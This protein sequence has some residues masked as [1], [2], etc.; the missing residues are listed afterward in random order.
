[1][2]TLPSC[3]F[4]TCHFSGNFWQNSKMLHEFYVKHYCH[5]VVTNNKECIY[6]E[7]TCSRRHTRTHIDRLFVRPVEVRLSQVTPLFC[8]VSLLAV[9]TSYPNIFMVCPLHSATKPVFT[10]LS[11]NAD[12][13]SSAVC[14]MS[15]TKNLLLAL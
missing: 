3:V 4:V 6:S 13:P 1:L 7:S 9:W 2:A 10:R 14:D 5:L 15:C 11:Q 8:R 12:L